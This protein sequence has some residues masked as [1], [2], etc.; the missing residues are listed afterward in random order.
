VSK[1]IAIPKKEKVKVKP[2]KAGLGGWLIVVGFGLIVGAVVGPFGLVGYIS[3]LFDQLAIPGFTTVLLV[4]IVFQTIF[5]VFDIY[6]LFLFFKKK[7]KFPEL[8]ILFLYFLIAWSIID[9]VLVAH[10]SASTPQLKKFLDEYLSETT[11]EM[12]RT[13]LSSFI[14]IIYTHKSKRVKATF[15]KD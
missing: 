6:L 13:I 9:Y 10:L 8:Y 1:K 3:L 5:V 7:K 12:G 2:V 11:K 4:E 14:W 15:V